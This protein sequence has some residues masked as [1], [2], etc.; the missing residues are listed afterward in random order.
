MVDL[1]KFRA[2]DRTYLLAAAGES[3]GSE[4][5]VIL[6]LP[7]TAHNST[8]PSVHLH[9]VTPERDVEGLFFERLG[10]RSQRRDNRFPSVEE[11]IQA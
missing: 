6:P 7:G 9:V 11:L 2:C 1:K 10:A 5:E 8:R 3:S 4:K